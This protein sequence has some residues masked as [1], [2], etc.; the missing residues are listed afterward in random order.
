M[1]T[2]LRTKAT[3]MLDKIKAGTSFADAA[4]A[5]KLK[6]EWRPG[7]KRGAPPAGLTPAAVTEIFK[8][9][10]DS[11]G[12]VEGASPT[13]RIVFRVTEI[14]VPPLDRGGR[15][16]QTSRRSA[17][18]AQR[19]RPDRAIYRAP[20]ERDRRHHQCERAEPG[21]WRR[22][23]ELKPPCRSSHRPTPS[24]RATTGAKPQVVWTTLVAD[25]E[26]PVSAFLKIAGSRPMSFLFESVEGGAV[27]GRYSVIGL[28]P[29]LIW[30][31]NGA[32][33][34]INRTARGKPDGFAPCPQPPLEALR[35]LIAESRIALPEG[36]PPMAAGVFGYLGYDMVRLMEE[37]PA[38]HPDPIGIPDAVLI[39]PTLVVVFDAVKDSH[40]RGHAG[41]A[42]ARR[43]GKS[44]ACPRE[45]APH[46][47]GRCA[48]PAARQGRRRSRARPAR[49]S[50][51][52]QHL[53]G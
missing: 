19:R 36:L 40:H 30:R 46:R 15:R 9:P 51:E 37:L 1:T 17:E 23:A 18:G 16:R 12:S 3:E 5:D 7:I 6:V 26:T 27:R 29:D 41:A 53:A 2:R 4:A 44:G 11:V 47:R 48:R 28:D 32:R 20:A 14:K 45:R 50:A 22:H 13:E 39:R 38:S 35:A 49:Y 42:R 52:I 31:T 8:S 33:A 24:P 21:H 34:E 10:Q 43:R 25:L